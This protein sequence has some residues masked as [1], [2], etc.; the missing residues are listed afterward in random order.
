MSRARALT[1]AAI[2]AGTVVAL[3]AL[4]SAQATVSTDVVVNEVY[5]GGATP[6]PR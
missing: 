6:A 2:A 3:L 5:G 4:P 1:A